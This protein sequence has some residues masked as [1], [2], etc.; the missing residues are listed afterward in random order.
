MPDRTL[1]NAATGKFLTCYA[2]PAPLLRRGAG[3]PCLVPHSASPS[4]IAALCRRS[5]CVCSGSRHAP[6]AAPRLSP[7][8][9]F[10]ATC[11]VSL[12]PSEPSGLLG[13]SFCH[14]RTRLCGY[15]RGWKSGVPSS[16]PHLSFP[17][18]RESRK[19]AIY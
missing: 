3:A 4:G 16:C 10:G 5:C 11:G 7:F 9:C 8:A 1:F 15:R 18:K 2:P 6:P 13:Y 14:S 19:K 12:R 17:Q